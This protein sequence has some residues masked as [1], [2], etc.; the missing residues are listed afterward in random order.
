LKP[1][2]TALAAAVL[3]ACAAFPAQAAPRPA[4]PPPPPQASYADLADLS[5]S[6][7]I[8][9]Q[10]EVR[11]MARVEPARA[12]DVRPGWARYYIEARTKVLITGNAVLGESLRYLVDVKLDARG[13]APSL[14]RKQVLLFGRMVPGRANELQLAA[15]DAQ[16]V[17][18]PELETRLRAVLAE[19]VAPDAPPRVTGVR[20]AIHVPGTLLGEGETQIFLTTRN[21]SAAMMTVARQAGRAP[22]WGATFSE[23]AEGPLVPPAPE[24]LAWYRLACFLPP[25]LPRGSNLSETATDRATAEGDYRFVLGQLGACPRLRN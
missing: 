22:Q 16:L 1:L 20:E 7:Q 15:P 4:P 3:A 12:P 25:S 24:T 2:F 13:K 18:D 11:R 19:L 10:A 21:E 6:A 5:D 14:G 8:V 17:W 9:I 23:I